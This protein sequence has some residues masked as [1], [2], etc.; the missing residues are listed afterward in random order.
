[1]VEREKLS[2]ELHELIH[3]NWDR[4]LEKCEA[5][6]KRNEFGQVVISRDDEWFYEDEWDEL[7]KELQR[8]D[9][10]AGDSAKEN[11]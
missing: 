11:G 8:R 7:Y 4:I 5:N 6:T 1:M 3:A 2:K 10:E 9:K